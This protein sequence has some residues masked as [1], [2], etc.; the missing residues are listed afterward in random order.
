MV[1]VVESADK[2]AVK[3]EVTLLK[4][5]LI[6]QGVTSCLQVAKTASILIIGIYLI[7][8]GEINIGSLVAVIQLDDV[9]SVPVE[10]LTYLQ[11][12]FR[13]EGRSPVS[14]LKALEK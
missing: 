2:K 6:V 4:H 14:R 8:R 5:Q 12:H 11:Y 1:R 7:S 10:V 13:L 9:I 3:G